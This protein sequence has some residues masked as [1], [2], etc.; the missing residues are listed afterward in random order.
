MSN[1]VIRHLADLDLRG[2]LVFGKNHT[3][4]PESPRKGEAV[5]KDG[6]LWTYTTIGGY[7]TWYPLTNK[8]NTYIHQQ[9]VPS[10]TWTVNHGLATE[11]VMLAV[12]DSTNTLTYS[13]LTIVSAD[14]L[15]LEF[16]E[17]VSGRVVIFADSDVF[18]PRVQSKSL[19]AESLDI[20][21]VVVADGTGLTISGFRPAM[22]DAG[23]KLMSTHI[24]ASIGTTVLT[25]QQLIAKDTNS[26]IG[27]SITPF[28]SAHIGALTTTSLASGSVSATSVTVGTAV[29]ADE[30]GLLVNGSRPALVDA[31]G[32]LPTQYLPSS[33]A[34]QQLSASGAGSAI[35][36]ALTPFAYANIDTITAAAYLPKT[37]DATIGTPTQ[38]FSS[39]YIDE[40]YLSANTLYV[41]GIPVIK[42]S[43][44]SMQFTA[45]P[46]QGMRLATTG[47]GRLLL[48]SE[49]GTSV[50]TTG[51]NADVSVQASGTGSLV[52]MTSN[53]EVKLT[54]P[55][56][57]LAGAAKVTGA[58]TV[59]GNLI[60]TG[61]VAD[62]SVTA[63]KIQDNII[64]L[65]AE[66]SS[67]GVSSQYA[68]LMI[69][70]GD[71]VNDRLVFDE[72]D[73][74]WKAGPVGS[75]KTLA[76]LTDVYTRTEADNRY[77]AAGSIIDGGSF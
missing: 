33:L 2:S 25:A 65:N 23:G 31:N 38:R 52:R 59:A 34:L 7:E 64:V 28:K 47:T 36:T 49:S 35:G 50:Q 71:S 12:Y 70:R 44:E 56:V 63:L 67:A 37:A 75:E 51:M 62:L 55:T 30:T 39:A 14:Q 29:V 6:A 17:A 76:L 72:V 8:K 58:L 19:A 11:N 24:P 18:V 4:F 15:V 5:L 9:A 61:D 40:L 16:A 26:T 20:A 48:D 77:M 41:D 60:V 21:G 1:A 53:T 10:T 57:T 54:A 46:N 43:T 27:S 45:D 68:G 74:R 22:V 42:S 32:K 3:T 13:G 66:E 73:D 69:E